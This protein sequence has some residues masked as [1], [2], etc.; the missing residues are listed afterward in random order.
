MNARGTLKKFQGCPRRTRISPWVAALDTSNR[1]FFS[2]NGYSASIK[3]VFF[4]FL[5]SID[6]VRPFLT[7]TCETRSLALPAEEYPPI[8]RVAV[9]HDAFQTLRR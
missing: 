4:L 6:N 2:S 9:L 5:P 7:A 1:S 3:F 8:L